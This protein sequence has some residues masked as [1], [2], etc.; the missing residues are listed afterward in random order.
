LG[1]ELKDDVGKHRIANL[2]ERIVG[3]VGG[4]EGKLFVVE[5]VVTGSQMVADSLLLNWT[6]PSCMC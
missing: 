1:Q 6:G 5:S 3:R 4:L 2:D